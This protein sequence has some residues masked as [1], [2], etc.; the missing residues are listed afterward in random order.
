MNKV[1][2]EIYQGILIPMGFDPEESIEYFKKLL[3]DI[4]GTQINFPISPEIKVKV[5]IKVLNSLRGQKRKLWKLYKTHIREEII[6]KFSSTIYFKDQNFEELKSTNFNSNDFYLK[7]LL[8]PNFEKRYYDFIVAL[9]I[10]RVGALHPGTGLLFSNGFFLRPLKPLNLYS[11]DILSY[12]LEKKWPVFEQ[13]NIHKTWSWYLTKAFPKGIDEISST[14]LSRAINAFTYLYQENI[15]EQERLFWTMVGIESLYVGGKEAIGEQVRK[16]AQIFLGEIKEFKKRLTKMYDYRSAFV[17][18]SKDF[19]GY[20]HIHD[21][22]DTF[23]KFI[24]DSEDPVQV[25]K[26]LLL[27]TLQKMAKYELDDL[28]FEYILK[29]KSS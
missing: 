24:E 21:G 7:H 12:S 1:K 23:D 15:S 4:N 27:A 25:A 19:P 14:N 6:L 3:S 29:T 5:R 18:G 9:D 10:A 28:E 2:I 11:I 16:K 8:I 22:L 26:S 20:F 17:H 13:L